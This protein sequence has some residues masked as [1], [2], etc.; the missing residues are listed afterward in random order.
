[1]SDVRSQVEHRNYNV[2]TSK[3]FTA[4]ELAERADFTQF[5]NDIEQTKEE[6]LDN[7]SQVI[8]DIQSG[9][10][11]VSGAGANSVGQPSDRRCDDWE[12]TEEYQS[13]TALLKY[14][15]DRATLNK[16]DQVRRKQAS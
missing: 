15:L 14:Q 6:L 13:K 3:P 5:E 16:I 2:K 7:A 9:S 8:R 12:M 4:L 1:M 11:S 10:N